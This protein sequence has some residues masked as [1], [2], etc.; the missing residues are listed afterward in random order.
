[1]DWRS[2]LHSARK[3]DLVMQGKASYVTTTSNWVRLVIA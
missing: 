2:T 3:D 1:M